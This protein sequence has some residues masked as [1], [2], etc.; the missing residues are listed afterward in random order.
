[1]KVLIAIPALD[2]VATDFAMSL[3]A[4]LGHTTT[5]SL[6]REVKVSLWCQKGSIIMDARNA[7]VEKALEIEATHILFLDSDMTFPP[8]TLQ[9]LAAHQKDIVGATYIRRVPPYNLLGSPA[10]ETTAS[11]LRLM[12]T[13]PF[14]CI[15]L[16][17]K[18]FEKL[19]RPYFRYITTEN[20]TISED[21]WFCIQAGEV[22][23]QVWCDPALTGLLGHIGTHIYRSPS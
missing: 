5:D 23:L 3:A 11:A 21:E 19:T 22:G 6:R 13:M 4:L 20:G 2:Y 16:K 12:A 15:L 17:T 1:M 10:R 18:V 9:R 8:D 14:G 7:C